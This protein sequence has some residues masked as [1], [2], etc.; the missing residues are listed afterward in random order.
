MF[1][2]IYFQVYVVKLSK[3]CLFSAIFRGDNEAE[4]FCEKRQLH[5]NVSVYFSVAFTFRPML[6]LLTCMHTYLAAGAIQLC[7]DLN[8]FL[9]FGNCFSFIFVGGVCICSLHNLQ[10]PLPFESSCCC[11]QEMENSEIQVLCDQR[12]SFYISGCS[13][14]KYQFHNFTFSI[15]VYI[16]SFPPSVISFPFFLFKKL[17]F[18]LCSLCA[19]HCFTCIFG[20]FNRQLSAFLASTCMGLG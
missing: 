3:H 5:S 16:V 14:C 1:L 10:G 13:A 4:R 18:S 12:H 20:V 17:F 7:P 2:S 19:G 11:R 15:L 8:C 9:I 6:D